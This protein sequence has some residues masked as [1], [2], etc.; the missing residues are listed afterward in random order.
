MTEGKYFGWAN[1]ET[2]VVALWLD[3]DDPVGQYWH[4]EAVG[5]I[6][7]IDSHDYQSTGLVPTK[8]KAMVSFAEDLKN[9][10]H[11]KS[12]LQ[13]PSLYR[14][15]V[16]KALRNVNWNELTERLVANAARPPKCQAPLQA[17]KLP[18]APKVRND[19]E[20]PAMSDAITRTAAKELVE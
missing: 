20:P 16:R 8:E 10:I 14:D 17:Q 6:Q 15:L 12:P 19:R 11:A 7:Q 2:F 9:A 4:K 3:R 1:F 13:G 5:I 18:P